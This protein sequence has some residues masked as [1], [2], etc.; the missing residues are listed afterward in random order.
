M[1]KRFTEHDNKFEVW[2]TELKSL[3]ARFSNGESSWS[4]QGSDVP[5]SKSQEAC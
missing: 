3:C 2:T 1:D 5:N 4:K